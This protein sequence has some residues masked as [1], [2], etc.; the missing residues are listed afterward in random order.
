[1]RNVRRRVPILPPDEVAG[2]QGGS[3]EEYRR[4]V[5]RVDAP[6]PGWLEPIQTPPE[7]HDPV[8][9][10]NTA[11]D[12]LTPWLHSHRVKQELPSHYE[13]VRKR[14]PRGTPSV[15]VSPV[16]EPPSRHLIQWQ[17]RDTPSDVP[18]RSRRPGSRRL[19]AEHHLAGK[20][21][22]S[23]LVPGLSTP[24]NLRD[25]AASLARSRR[26]LRHR[27]NPPGRP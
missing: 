8:D 22:P 23:R 16:R 14:A 11:T 2:V 6:P 9:P 13:S 4:S 15:L 18:H 27:L 5:G 20:R 19:H 25:T 10:T 3:R 12:D 24:R 21:A 1:M 17:Y 26:V 7:P